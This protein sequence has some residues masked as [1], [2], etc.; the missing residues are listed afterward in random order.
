M[1]ILKKRKQPATGCLGVEHERI[2]ASKMP[3]TQAD[4]LDA[5]VRLRPIFGAMWPEDLAPKHVYQYLR[6]RQA[7]VRANR[8][9]AVLSNVMQQAIEMG[10]IDANP[11]KQ[12]RRNSESP[13]ERAVTDADLAGFPPDRTIASV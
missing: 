4:Y 9:I 3:R 13:R 11:C 10:L 1:A 6:E 5:I 12:V 7:K 8:E 2:L